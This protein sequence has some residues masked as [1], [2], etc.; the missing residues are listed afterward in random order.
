MTKA[1][2]LAW[3]SIIIPAVAWDVA[4]ARW[5]HS[6]WYAPLDDP[7]LNVGGWYMGA[8]VGVFTIILI[9]AAVGG[10][11]AWLRWISKEPPALTAEGKRDQRRYP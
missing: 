3:S 2:K 10:I 9:G 5:Y 4:V 7:V 11:V 1:K 6:G 8:A